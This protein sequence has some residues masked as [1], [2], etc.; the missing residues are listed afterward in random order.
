MED[1]DLIIPDVVLD[2][3]C[4]LSDYS[5]CESAIGFLQSNA[6]DSHRDTLAFSTA[7]RRAGSASRRIWDAHSMNSSMDE[8]V[9]QSLVNLVSGVQGDGLRPQQL[10]R[11]LP[12][13]APAYS[14]IDADACC[15][16]AALAHPVTVSLGPEGEAPP[17]RAWQHVR[18]PLLQ[19]RG[20][21]ILWQCTSSH[22]L[23]NQIPQTRSDTS[24]SLA[25]R[26]GVRT[27]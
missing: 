3:H 11:H 8:T 10:P 12:C 15:R 20:A 4:N 16:T 2:Y 17:S 18:P 19:A 6:K 25:E 27:C 5:Q 21:G 22:G 7:L 14:G 26:A 9:D 1:D 23:S 13:I 24:L